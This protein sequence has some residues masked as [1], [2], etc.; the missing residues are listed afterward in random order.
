MRICRTTSLNINFISSNLKTKFL[1]LL[2]FDYLPIPSKRFI[3]LEV[4]KYTLLTNIKTIPSTPIAI[5]NSG[6]TI[7][8]NIRAPTMVNII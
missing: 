3:F 1:S 7:T 5:K 4:F 6:L 2:Y 8:V